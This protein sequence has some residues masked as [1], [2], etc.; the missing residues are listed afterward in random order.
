MPGHWRGLHN[1]QF[2]KIYFKNL[3][4]KLNSRN[5]LNIGAQ[6]PTHSPKEFS[7]NDNDT[8]TAERAHVV[9]PLVEGNE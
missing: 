3:V 6:L 9:T 4:K 1:R 5:R 2:F 8:E 7:G